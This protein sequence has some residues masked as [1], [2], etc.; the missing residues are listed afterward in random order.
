MSAEDIPSQPQP[1][2]DAR[3]AYGADPNQFLEVRQPTTKAPYPVLLNIHGGYWRAEYD[4]AH[5]GH[6]CER[7]ASRPST[8]NTGGLATPVADGPEPL[9]TSARPTG[10]CSRSIPDSISIWA[11]WWSWDIPP[12]GNSRYVWRRTKPRSTAQF[13]SPE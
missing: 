6:L 11:A 10:F 1:Q 13:L 3:V 8:P 12:A 2:P 5:A 9:R 7:Q 4:L